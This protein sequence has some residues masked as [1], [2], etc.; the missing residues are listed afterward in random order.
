[1]IIS[2]CG[3]EVNPVWNAGD[4]SVGVESTVFGV[5]IIALLV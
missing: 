4:E 5:D 2:H 3:M 1:M